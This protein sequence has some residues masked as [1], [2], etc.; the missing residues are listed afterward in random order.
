[1]L[2]HR[3]AV[4]AMVVLATAM[5]AR[6]QVQTPA[7]V[8]YDSFMQQDL[9]GRLRTFNQVTAEN[10]AEL[11]QTQIKR[12]VEQNRTR[13]TSEQLKVMDENLAYVTADRY[14]QP[15]TQEERAKAKEVEARTAAVFTREDMVQALTINA[16]YIPK[17]N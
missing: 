6:A 15:M 17:K 11:V 8:D 1:M 9:Q 10:R 5:P 13:L 3:L 14:R 12:W 7:S 16:T 2:R 4:F